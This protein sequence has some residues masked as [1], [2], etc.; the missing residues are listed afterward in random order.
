MSAVLQ[1]TVISANYLLSVNDP[2][3][4]VFVD[5]SNIAS[6]QPTIFI[7]TLLCRYFIFPVSHTNI[8][9]TNKDLTGLSILNFLTFVIKQQAFDVGIKDADASGARFV[10]RG[11]RNRGI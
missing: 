3:V 6:L 11:I 8:W 9:T 1:T 5:Y 2:V 7:E 4:T 10:S